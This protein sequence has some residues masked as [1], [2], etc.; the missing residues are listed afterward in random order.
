[1]IAKPITKLPTAKNFKLTDDKK[2]KL[3]EIIAEINSKMGKSY[4]IDVA[5]K[6]A[7]QIRDNMMKSDELK[8][9][10]KNNAEGDFEFSYSSNVEDALIEGFDKKQDFFSYLLDHSEAQ[11]EILGIFISEI[12]KNLREEG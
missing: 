12:Y 11:K 8:I 7:M 3:S 1:M 6:T 2:Q 10:A 5:T 4:D 9:S